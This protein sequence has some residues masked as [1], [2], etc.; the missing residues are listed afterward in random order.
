MT[1]ALAAAGLSGA[2]ALTTFTISAARI[3][4]GRPFEGMVGSVVFATELTSQR[5]TL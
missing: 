4:K 2:E 1:A 3:M 5:S